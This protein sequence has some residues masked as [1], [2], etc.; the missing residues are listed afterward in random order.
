MLAMFSISNDAAQDGYGLNDPIIVGCDTILP[1]TN[2]YVRAPASCGGLAI[3]PLA[4]AVIESNGA[5]PDRISLYSAS[6]MSGTGTLRITTPPSLA[7]T[8]APTAAPTTSA[9]WHCASP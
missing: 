3:S 5:D 2:G 4:A 1:D 6:S 9:S 7:P 8:R